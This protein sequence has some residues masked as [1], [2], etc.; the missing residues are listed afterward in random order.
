MSGN[1]SV[2]P[3]LWSE[4]MRSLASSGVRTYE[5]DWLFG[6]AQP[7]R[8]LEDGERFMD[9]MAQAAARE[10]ITL[11]YCMPLPRHFLQGSQY[12]NLTTIRTSPDRL[13][14]EHWR[15]FLFNGRL[16]TA[17]GEW[18]STDVFMSAE[19]DNLLLA[20]LS[21][22]IVGVGDAIGNSIATIFC[23]PSDPTA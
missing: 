15:P 1:V 10:G 11:Q 20:T 12:S 6:P 18:P 4:W 9:V 3:A 2:D 5:Q 17:L 7:E 8:N 16:A 19:T 23:A 22:G 21:G 13:S 14:R